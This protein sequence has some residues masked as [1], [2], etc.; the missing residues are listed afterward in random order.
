MPK[1]QMGHLKIVY[2][3]MIIVTPKE[4]KNKDLFFEVGK[5]EKYLTFYDFLK[6]TTTVPLSYEPNSLVFLIQIN[7]RLHRH[8]NKQY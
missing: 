4:M 7:I 2:D 6:K 5:C 3:C 1:H 8:P